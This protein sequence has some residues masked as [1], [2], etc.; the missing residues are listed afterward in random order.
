MKNYL[1][2]VVA[3]AFLIVLAACGQKFSGKYADKNGMVTYDF[4]S[5][6][7]VVT[8]GGGL[9]TEMEYSLE[10]NKIKIKNP[11]GTLI[12]PINKDGSITVMGMKLYK[13]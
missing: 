4:K 8:E 7:T 6:G 13:Q 5:N 1:G 9:S 11:L 10:D 3:S 12:V 2:L